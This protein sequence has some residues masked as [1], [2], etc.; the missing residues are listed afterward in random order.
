MYKKTQRN[1]NPCHLCAAAHVSAGGRYTP[2]RAQVCSYC[3]E[4][5][6]F[7][8]YLE[9]KR[10]YQ[11]GAVIT[12]LDELLKEEWIYWHGRARHH[13]VIRNQSL[14]FILLQLNRGEYHQAIKKGEAL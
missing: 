14:T 9:S 1:C 3:T 6:A 12:T 7:E 11:E 10:K 5:K 13:T 2:G 4:R 8:N